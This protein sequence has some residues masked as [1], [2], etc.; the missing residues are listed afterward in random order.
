MAEV[1]DALY[2]VCLLKT[3]Q[4]LKNFAVVYQITMRAKLLFIMIR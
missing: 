4:F 2:N 1:S 3:Y